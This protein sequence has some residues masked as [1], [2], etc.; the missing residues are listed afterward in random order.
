MHFWAEDYFKTLED[1]AAEAR[2]VPE[3]ADYAAFCEEYGRGLRRKAFTILERF[4][5]HS[6]RAPFAER[7]RFVSWLSRIADRRKGRHRLI[8]HP[9]QVRVVEPT[10]LEW[11]A[12]EPHRAE[13]HLWLGGYDHVKRAFEL[14]PDS[15]LARRKLIILVWARVDFESYE[16]GHL[17]NIE[18]DLATLS[19]VEGL[20][21]GLSNEDDRLRL[22]ADLAEDRRLIKEHLPKQSGC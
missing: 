6:E 19:E 1:V 8:P 16:L 22:V 7:R 14:E 2:A 13:P 11:M 20:L 4:M 5:S 12:I 10:L 9:L 17:S 21:D 15:Q 3:W 18:K